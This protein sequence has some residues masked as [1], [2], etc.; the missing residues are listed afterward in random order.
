[1]QHNPDTLENNLVISYNVKNTLI[2][3][4]CNPLPVIYLSETKPYV[5]TKTYMWMFTVALFIFVQN[6]KQSKCLN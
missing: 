6:W 4:P 1:M 5:H 3:K 2:I